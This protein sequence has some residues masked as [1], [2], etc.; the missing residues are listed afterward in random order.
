M[1]DNVRAQP[2]SFTSDVSVT[3]VVFPLKLPTVHYNTLCV[4]ASAISFEMLRNGMFCLLVKIRVVLSFLELFFFLN[5]VLLF[6]FQLCIKGRHVF[7]GYLKNEE[8][9]LE[10]LDS[11]G[12]L[13]SGDIGKIDEVSSAVW[14]LNRFRVIKCSPL[15][16]LNADL[17]ALYK[18][19]LL[20][21]TS[22]HDLIQ[23]S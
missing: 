23:D 4:I 3:V 1:Y 11:E 15:H 18:F 6:A 19:L 17:F 22:F 12:W 16:E 20:P 8:K 2:L 9:T 10:A 5:Q 21:H 13:H 14:K 7:M